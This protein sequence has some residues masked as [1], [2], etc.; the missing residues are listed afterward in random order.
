MEGLTFIIYGGNM[1]KDKFNI[2]NIPTVLWGEKSE[3]LLL[4]CMETCQIKKIQ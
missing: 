2:S 3:K 4:Q 1:F